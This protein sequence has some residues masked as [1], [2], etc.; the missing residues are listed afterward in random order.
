MN[1][2]RMAEWF[3]DFYSAVIIRQGLLC[4]GSPLFNRALTPLFDL[5]S[6]AYVVQARDVHPCCMVSRCQVSRCQVS[7]F[8][9]T[10]HEKQE[11]AS[12]PTSGLASCF[13]LG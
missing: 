6:A 4:S 9:I 12:L 8:H 10:L 13:Q 1:A 11:T 2:D 7:R 5:V 3:S